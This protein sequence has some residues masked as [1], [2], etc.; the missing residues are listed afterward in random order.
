[1]AFGFAEGEQWA[2]DCCIADVRVDVCRCGGVDEAVELQSV[3]RVKGSAQL[4]SILLGKSL[5]ER[6][7]EC[8]HGSSGH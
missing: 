5:L 2:V 1:M 4:I 3:G 6:G 8:G 7:K